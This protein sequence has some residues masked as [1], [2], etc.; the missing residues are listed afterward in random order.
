MSKIIKTINKEV[1]AKTA[2]RCKDLKVVIPTFEQLRH[3]ETI[4]ESIKNQLPGVGFWDVN[5]LNLFRIT[6]KNAKKNIFIC[7]CIPNHAI[8]NPVTAVSGKNRI[9]SIG[10]L[11]IPFA[12]GDNPI[13]NPRGSATRMA[14]R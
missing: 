2:K 14:M 9:A 12:I 13:M 1:R 6:W 7:D 3:P 8:N 11:K 5:P 10:L 4:P